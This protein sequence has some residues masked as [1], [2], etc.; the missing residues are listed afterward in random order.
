MK[1]KITFKKVHQYSQEY[2]SKEEHTKAQ[3]F[4]DL[5]SN[6]KKF[7]DL[8]ADVKQI[9]GSHFETAPIEVSAPHGY[10]GPFDHD[11]FRQEVEIYFR[12]AFGSTGSAIRIGEGA[13]NFR[14]ENNIYIKT[15]VIEF[16][17]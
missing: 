9:I 6:G 2:G 4:F 8:Y 14:M 13:K 3:V 1:I 15:K 16:E 10:S 7:P 12:D 17:V 5:E 11:I